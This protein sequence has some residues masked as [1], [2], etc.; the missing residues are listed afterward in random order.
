MTDGEA[1]ATAPGRGRGSSGGGETV[2]GDAG[3][4]CWS[5]RRRHRAEL[6]VGDG[7]AAPAGMQQW[8]ATGRTDLR[9]E[10]EDAVPPRAMGVLGGSSDRDSRGGISSSEDDWTMRRKEAS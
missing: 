9:A 4:G 6:D 10:A 3:P 8:R 2:T 5:G 1:E 7:D